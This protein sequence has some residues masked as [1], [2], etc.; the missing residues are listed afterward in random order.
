MLVKEPVIELPLPE[1]AIPETSTVLF[2]VHVNVV[3]DILLGLLI[4]IAEIAF[5]LHNV[6]CVSGVAATVGTRLITTVV[7]VTVVQ[8]DD[9]TV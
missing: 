3:P 1:A 6:S 5:P 9:V 7:V 8:P 4:D 2:L